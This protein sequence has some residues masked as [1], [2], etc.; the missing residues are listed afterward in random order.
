LILCCRD[1]AES[2][3]CK[4]TL[5]VDKTKKTGPIVTNKRQ[6]TSAAKNT[7]LSPPLIFKAWPG[8][9]KKGIKVIANWIFR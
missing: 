8:K 2:H 9:N 4:A 5:I 3:I 7:A 1:E 6:K